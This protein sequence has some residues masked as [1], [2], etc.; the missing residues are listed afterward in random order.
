MIR[1]LSEHGAFFLREGG[2]HSLY[3]RGNLRTLVPRHN[4][5]VEELA[6]KICRDLDIPW[7]KQ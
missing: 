5:I 3:Q 6:R 4:E 1:H 7:V 2:R